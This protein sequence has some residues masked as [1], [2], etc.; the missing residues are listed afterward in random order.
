MSREEARSSRPRSAARAARTAAPPRGRAR[1]RRC[2]AAR[3]SRSSPRPARRAR[4]RRCRRS[5]AAPRSRS[6]SGRTRP[7][8]CPPTAR[9]PRRSASHHS[10]SNSDRN[11]K[12]TRTKPASLQKFE[13]TPRPANQSATQP[14]RASAPTP[15]SHHSLPRASGSASQIVAR[16]SGQDEERRDEDRAGLGEP[17]QALRDRAE[18]DE[19]ARTRPPSASARLR[20]SSV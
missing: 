15:S 4:A 16:N 5:R 19:P 14:T 20:P 10:S 8:R 7:T 11:Q 12:P 13:R 17:R 1:R 9:A 6:A 18:R 2:R 3:C